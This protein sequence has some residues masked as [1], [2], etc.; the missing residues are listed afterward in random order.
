M[1]HIDKI[2]FYI[3]LNY[4]NNGLSKYMQSNILI[5]IYCIIYYLKNK[6]SWL[7]TKNYTITKILDNEV[8]NLYD[9]LIN[10]NF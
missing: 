2:V 4:V 5:F 10:D 8:G 3:S 1:T 7:Y 6:F 9:K